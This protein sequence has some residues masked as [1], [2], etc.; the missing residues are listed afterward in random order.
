MTRHVSEHGVARKLTRHVHLSWQRTLVAIGCAAIVVVATT[1]AAIHVANNRG[2]D[3]SPWFAPY[4]DVTAT[5]TYHFENPTDP[6]DRDIVLSFIVA[7]PQQACTPSWGAAYTLDSAS[8]GLDLDRRIVELRKNG[9]DVVVS[10]GGQANQELSSVCTDPTKLAAAYKSVVDRYDLSTIDLDVEGASLNAA[11]DTRRAA[12]IATVQ[13]AE[14]AA[15]H[16]LAVWLTLPV[17]PTGLTDDGAAVLQTML[18]AHVDVAGVNAMTMDYGSS[19]A[20]G[21][22]EISA[23]TDALRAT[24]HQV[25]VLYSQANIHLTSAE[26]WAKIGATPMIGQNDEVAESF[27]LAA[28]TTLTAFVKSE[29][30]ARISMW[31]LN[32]DA[33]C[34]AN[35]PN[36][37]VVSNNCSG[38]SQAPIA[39]SKVFGQLPGRPV[40]QA[41]AVTTS[42]PSAVPTVDN[43]AT[44][45]YPIWVSTAAYPAGSK[46]V[47]HHNVYQAKWWA[48]GQLPDAPVLQA[49]ETPWT[50]VGPVLPGEHP[51]PLP[52]LPAGT[53]PAWSSSA[54]YLAGA[55]VLYDNVGY[56][57]KWW[58][59]GDQPGA[60]VNDPGDTPWELIPAPTL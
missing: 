41:S 49:Y 26:L 19:L 2:R 22:T 14:R 13:T 54:T 59:Q 30:M 5:P 25:G 57:A 40:D 43:P 37:T 18:A 38:V 50:L 4:V 20:K 60:T 8:I 33:A 28:A 3:T 47:W 48:Q 34:G 51:A 24:Q 52:T 21:Q 36:V 29:G 23:T 10:F 6:A 15:G 35:Y 9:G 56:Q 32:R 42:D 1:A 46:V 11:A 53:Y 12:A 39:F 7:D 31:S 58:T 45:P 17:A 55:R 27:N 16:S 44:S